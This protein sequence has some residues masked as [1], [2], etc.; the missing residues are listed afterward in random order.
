FS[1]AFGG[2]LDRV[3]LVFKNGLAVIKQSS[4]QGGFAI[5]D[6]ARCAKPQQ[7]GIVKCFYHGGIIICCVLIHCFVRW[8]TVIL[9]F[10]KIKNYIFSSQL[11]ALSF[12]LSTFNF[13]LS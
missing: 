1:P 2:S 6:G 8:W 7:F 12:Q 10:L 4:D 3:V 11:S 5:I 9:S 13:Q